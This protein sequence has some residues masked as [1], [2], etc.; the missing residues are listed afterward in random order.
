M[1]NVVTGEAVVLDVRTAR[2]PTRSLALFIDILAQACLLLSIV[3]IASQAGSATDAALTQAIS[4]V[5]VVL[6]IVGYPVTLESL[7][8]GRSLGKAA[9]GLRVVSDDGGPERFRQ[10]LFRGLTGFVEIWLTFGVVALLTSL[11]S[12]DGR[13]LGDIFAGTV[14]VRERMPV[15]GG[16]VATM[17]PHLAG[18]AAG[19][20]L[21]GLTD[22][23]AL[24]ARQYTS[25]YHELAPQARDAMG[26]QI[27]SAVAEHVSPAPPA[28]TTPL[29]FLSA[30]LAERRR[31]EESRLMTQQAQRDPYGQ[32]DPYGQQQP[33]GA[34][35]HPDGSQ[36]PAAA[37]S[38]SDSWRPQ[39][40]HRPRAAPE[41]YP[42]DPATDRPPPDSGRESG[43][44][45]HPSPRDGSPGG[46][47]PPS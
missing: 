5:V 29:A 37:G 43:A 2:L 12:R 23:L 38:G 41:S 26:R 40:T 7:W 1:T 36:Q 19:L 39:D 46:F 32:P 16:P 15:R 42:Y 27:A 45:R 22:E 10:A 25:R 9:L 14:A 31:R 11:L 4:L 13:R 33:F 47:A 28:G 8:R 30:V 34:S 6:V 17:P 24:T 3:A 18:W 20:E 21:S 35:T 44:E